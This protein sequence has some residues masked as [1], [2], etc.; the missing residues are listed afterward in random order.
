[1]NGNKKINE[2]IQLSEVGRRG[3]ASKGSS[4]V[5]DEP[6]EALPTEGSV[7]KR[8]EW[9]TALRLLGGRV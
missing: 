1:M 6:S 7:L 5:K 8:M 3:R 4:E 9:S 2:P